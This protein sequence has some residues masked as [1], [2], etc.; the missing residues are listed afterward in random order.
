MKNGQTHLLMFGFEGMMKKRVNYKKILFVLPIF[1]LFSAGCT[2]M[3][4][5]SELQIEVWWKAY[6]KNFV[7]PDGRIRRPEH[8]FDTVSEGQAYAMLFSLFMNDKDTFDLIYDWT[9][10]NLGRNNTQGDYL[11]AWH[12]EDGRV[13]DWMAA[14]DADGDYAFA[15]LL[16]SCRW[17]EKAYR[18]KAKLVVNDILKLETARGEDGHLFLL[19]G[20]WGKENTEHLIQNPSYYNPAAFRLFYET[21]QDSRWLDLIKTTYWIL[22]Q[23]G[24]CLGNIIGR[25]LVPD[26]CIVDARGNILSAEGRSSDYGWDAVRIPMRVGIDILWNTTDAGREVLKNIYSALQTASSDF[27]DVKAVYHYTGEPAVRYGSLPADA[28]AC[29]AAQ[30]LQINADTIK[31]SF[32]NKVKEESLSQNYYGQSLAFFPLAFEG[33][34]LKKP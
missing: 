28:M 7:L 30:T 12:W 8:G 9:E 31:T 15:L 32:R 6:K 2:A 29:F 3:K 11:L 13:T 26:W 18:D 5:P 19:P 22:C 23:S 20:L 24:T 25:S 17:K 4:S 27:E 21:T 1:C 34:I 33:G 10:K 16:A 14:S